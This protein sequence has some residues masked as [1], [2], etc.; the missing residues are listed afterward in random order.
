[1]SEGWPSHLDGYHRIYD[2][3]SHYTLGV[4]SHPAAS[5]PIAG[6]RRERLARVTLTASV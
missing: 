6:R 5:A 2:W 4:G 1:M 3:L